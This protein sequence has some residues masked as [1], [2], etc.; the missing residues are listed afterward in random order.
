MIDLEQINA[1]PPSR[2]TSWTAIVVLV[3][4]RL[5]TS[6]SALGEPA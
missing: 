3:G 4:G 2:T 5:S 1:A 6:T